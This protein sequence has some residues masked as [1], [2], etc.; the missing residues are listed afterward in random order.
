MVRNERQ[1]EKRGSL[2]S[3]SPTRTYMMNNGAGSEEFFRMAAHRQLILPQSFQPASLP[4]KQIQRWQ[5][6][7][8]R[9]CDKF[10][11]AVA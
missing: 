11:P 4:A 1:E 3:L 10:L 8:V 9:G 7:F 5:I 6:R 2:A